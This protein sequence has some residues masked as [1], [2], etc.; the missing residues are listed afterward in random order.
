MYSRGWA[1]VAFQEAGSAPAA[2]GSFRYVQAV[3]FPTLA[4]D[5]NN[6]GTVD[7]A[8]YVVWR[9]GLGTTYTQTDYDTWRANFGRSASNG[10]AAYALGAT[11]EPLSADVPEPPNIGLVIVSTAIATILSYRTRGAI[12]YPL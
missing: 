8:D 1:G 6:D 7:A 2:F 10:A 9:N 3:A 5:Y 12:W 11:A 4:G